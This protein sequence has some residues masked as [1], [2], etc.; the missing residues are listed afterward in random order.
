MWCI[1][2][3]IFLACEKICGTYN[4]SDLTI[5]TPTLPVR[6]PSPTNEKLLNI[7]EQKE[8]DRGKILKT[9]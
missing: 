9:N 1:F 5:K 6:K 2:Y 7:S 3:F 8:Q 4:Y